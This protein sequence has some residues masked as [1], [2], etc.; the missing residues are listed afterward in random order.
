MINDMDKKVSGLAAAAMAATLAQS[1]ILIFI[2]S[3]KSAH[4]L[5]PFL[6]MS[7]SEQL[8][9]SSQMKKKII[10]ITSCSF[11]GTLLET[12]LYYRNNDRIQ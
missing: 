5:L 11:T 10:I 3:L 6:P 7:Y 4:D 12:A 1:F 2:Y 9:A 8:R